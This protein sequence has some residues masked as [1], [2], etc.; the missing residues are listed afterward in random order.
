MIVSAEDDDFRL[1]WKQAFEP[2]RQSHS[3]KTSAHNHNPLGKVWRAGFVF[4]HV[5]VTVTIPT[6]RHSENFTFWTQRNEWGEHP[7]KFKPAKFRGD[8]VTSYGIPANLAK[9]IQKI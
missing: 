3:G 2:L 8:V 6:T 9:A 7:M 5:Q 1:R 4:I